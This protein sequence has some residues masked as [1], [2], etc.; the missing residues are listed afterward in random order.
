MPARFLACILP[1][2]LL[3]HG[4]DL[5]Q[6]SGQQLPVSDEVVD[7][8]GDLSREVVAQGRGTSFGDEVIPR[9]D[10]DAAERFAAYAGRR[11]IHA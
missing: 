7:Y 10:A 5:A 11:P 4:W 6:A 3:L 1:L 2:E 8:I 9:A